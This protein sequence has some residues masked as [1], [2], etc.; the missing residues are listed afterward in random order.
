[1]FNSISNVSSF[2]VSDSLREEDWI[3]VGDIPCWKQEIIHQGV[4]DMLV[5]IDKVHVFIKL[6]VTD[7]PDEKHT[8]EFDEHM[9][10]K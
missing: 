6:K 3:L 9:I 5:F 7:V 8:E 4:V 1:M 2:V 10:D